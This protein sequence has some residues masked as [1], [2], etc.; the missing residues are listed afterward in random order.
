MCMVLGL[1]HFDKC[2]R[3]GGIFLNVITEKVS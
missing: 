2:N 1:G 3:E